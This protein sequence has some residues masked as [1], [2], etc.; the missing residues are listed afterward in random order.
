MQGI[1]VIYTC[2]LQG[3]I[4]TQGFPVHITGKKLTVYVRIQPNALLCHEREYD[5][6]NDLDDVM[7]SGVTTYVR[8]AYVA[9]ATATASVFKTGPSGVQR[10]HLIINI[11][12]QYN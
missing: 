4:V 12:T 7:G 3:R 1:P 6:G 9:S 10:S 5:E 11:R 2:K 8:R